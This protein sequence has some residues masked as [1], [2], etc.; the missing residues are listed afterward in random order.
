[1][2]E[3]ALLA[4]GLPF[5]VHG[6]A[7]LERRAAKQML[8]RLR[9]RIAASEVATIVARE[10]AVAGFVAEASAGAGP[11]EQTRQADLARFVSLA[12]AYAG[13]D[14]TVG[15]FLAELERRFGGDVGR[16]AVQ[17]LTYHSAKGL[18]W[19]AV[20]LPRLEDGELPHWRASRQAMGD[21]ERRLLYVGMTRAKRHLWLSSTREGR[22]S[23]YLGALAATVS[24]PS[25]AAA[26]ASAGSR[27]PLPARSSGASGGWIPRW[28]R[29]R[30]PKR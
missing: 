11:A 23:P 19:E 22:P 20:F 27:P 18:E 28:I 9:S 17:L 21:E 7:F 16:D 10:V 13:S 1:M 25:R 6:G 2:F 24:R 8:P 30:R 5:V 29:D 4:V 3:E 15:G 12:A 26:R 14:E